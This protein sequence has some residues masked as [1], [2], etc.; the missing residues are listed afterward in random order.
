MEEDNRS[1]QEKLQTVEIINAEECEVTYH[2]EVS[3]K[4]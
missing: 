1:G 4:S 3:Q 2:K